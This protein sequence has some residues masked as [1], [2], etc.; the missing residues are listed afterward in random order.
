MKICKWGFHFL[1]REC[2]DDEDVIEAGTENAK[3]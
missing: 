2:Q 1:F 3:K